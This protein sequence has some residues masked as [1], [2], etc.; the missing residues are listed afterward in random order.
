MLFLGVSAALLLYQESSR[1]QPARSDTAE[2]AK[3][4]EP[5]PEAFIEGLRAIVG[6]DNVQLD[7]DR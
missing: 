6:H 5:L 2:E 1:K 4:G 3:G 7:L